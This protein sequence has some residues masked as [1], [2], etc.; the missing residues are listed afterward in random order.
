MTPPP[1]LPS[2]RYV[3]IEWSLTS[4]GTPCHGTRCKFSTGS[5]GILA[6]GVPWQSSRVCHSVQRRTTICHGSVVSFPRNSVVNCPH[7]PW[8][9]PM[10]F[11]GETKNP[12]QNSNLGFRLTISPPWYTIVHISRENCH[13]TIKSCHPLLVIAKILL[14]TALKMQGGLKCTAHD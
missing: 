9:Q 7:I 8:H 4:L 3:I 1:P 14:H 11:H 13:G 10:V 6:M 5:R 2:E 12:W